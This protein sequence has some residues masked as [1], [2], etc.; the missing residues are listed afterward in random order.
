MS[1]RTRPHVA[2]AALKRALRPG[3]GVPVIESRQLLQGKLMS[4][5]IDEALV[6]TGM[7]LEELPLPGAAA[8]TLIVRK[9]RLV[10]PRPG[11]T[12]E[13]GDHV[14]LIASPED[15]GFIQL[16]FGRPEEE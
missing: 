14:H 12:L 3:Q 1:G 13:T 4:F 16:M 5:Y 8:V 10:P 9:N 11:T 6:V 7:P 2:L 15:R